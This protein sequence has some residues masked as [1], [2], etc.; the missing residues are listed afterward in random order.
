MALKVNLR[1]GQPTRVSS[2]DVRRPRRS[3]RR[4]SAGAAR[5]TAA[6][7]GRHLRRGELGVGEGATPNDPP[8]PRLCPRCRG[9]RRADRC[10]HPFGGATAHRRAGRHLPF[11]RNRHRHRWRLR[12]QGLVDSRA[13]PPGHSRGGDL[14]GRGAGRGATASHQ[15]GPL[16]GRQGGSGNPRPREQ[17]RFG[18]GGDARGAAAHRQVRRRYAHRSDP[19][20]GTSHRGMDQPEL[21]GG[22]APPH[23]PRGGWL[24]IHSEHLRRRHQRPITG[25]A[26]WP[27]SP[28]AARLRAAA[29][30]RPSLFARAHLDRTGPHPGTDLRRYRWAAGQRRHLAAPRVP[31]DLSV[32]S[33]AG[34]PAQ[35]SSRGGRS[36]GTSHARLSH[37]LATV[38][39]CGCPTSRRW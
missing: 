26:T 10:T 24:G 2:V 23:G 8:E 25:A 33:L 39:S 36:H 1:E 38:A 18:E 5:I 19:E 6:V 4:R 14:F 13:D 17:A 15:R 20:R 16:R 32:V 35:R 22:D 11:R 21:S 31:L 29:L 7:G 34:R 30:S 37:E 3:S 28:I 9:G 12:H 27:H